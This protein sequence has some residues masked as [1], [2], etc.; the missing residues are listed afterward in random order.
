MPIIVVGTNH[1]AAPIEL[2]ERLAFRAEQLAPALEALRR[3]CGLSEAA[4]LSTCNR[5]EIYGHSPAP[6]RALQALAGF[7]SRH[8]GFE[9]E[10]LLPHL[11]R[12]GEP[13]SV[14][15]LFRVAS[16][17]DSM[18]LGEA[19]ILH[20]VKQAY[21]AA[22]S[23]GATGKALNVLFQKALNAGKAVRERTALGHGSVSVGSVAIEL[24]EKIFG[25]LRP[26]AVLLVGAG[27][28]GEI[29]LSRLAERG[30]RRLRILNRSPERAQA[31]AMRCGGTGGS[32]DELEASL[33][34]A[35]IVLVSTAS[36]TALL[37]REH[38]AQTMRRRRQRPLCLIDLSVPRNV[39]AAAGELE[40]FYLFDIDDLQGLVD[41]THEQRRHAVTESQRI[42]DEKAGHFLAWWQQEGTACAAASSSAPAAAS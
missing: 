24:A 12:F 5:V 42:V 18:V 15:H 14:R 17:L 31:L 39:D 33:A 1:A 6:D 36:P 22:R 28:I 29:T 37:T 23:S 35:D 26:Y 10:G 8:G 3:S 40:N 25:S 9:G 32:L 27:K 16:G 4:I 2:R 38:L 13:D 19:E 21:D 7:L 11:Y 34:E 20:Q 41:R 30:V